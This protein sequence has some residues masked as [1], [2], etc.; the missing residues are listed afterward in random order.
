MEDTFKIL[1]L[2]R[3]YYF[4]PE[5]ETAQS[6]L[7][8]AKRRYKKSYP[9]GGRPRYRIKASYQA[10]P[11]G[12]SQFAALMRFALRTRRGYRLVDYLITIHLIGT[13]Y[14][15]LVRVHPK[16]IPKFARKQAM[17]IG[18]IFR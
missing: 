10:V 5:E 17:G 8:K 2:A 18:A 3:E 9:K 4:Y 14:R 12:M 16:A 13:F 1:A 6:R 15:L 11:A 7:K